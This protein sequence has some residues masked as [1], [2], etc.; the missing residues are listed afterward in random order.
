MAGGEG[1]WGAAANGSG[2]SS[3]GGGNI[4]ELDRGWLHS[5]VNVLNATELLFKVTAFLVC[6]F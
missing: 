4:S 2:V 3:G 1:A 6:E 5:T